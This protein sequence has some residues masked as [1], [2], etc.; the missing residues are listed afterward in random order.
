M[1]ISQVF[2]EL[3]CTPA[4]LT[5]AEARQR[6]E[7]FGPN[8]LPQVKGPGPLR[9]LLAQFD[10]VLVV[11]MG[12]LTIEAG[13]SMPL[14]AFLAGL[15]L[16]ET[17]YRHQVEADIRPFRGLLLGLFFMTVGLSMDLGLVSERLTDVLVV[18]LGLLTLKAALIFVLCLA[19]RLPAEEALRAGFLLAQG[20]EFAFV[21]FDVA[22]A[23]QVLPLADGQ[24]LTAAVAL[25]MILTPFLAELGRLF[26]GRL[27]C[28][29]ASDLVALREETAALTDHVVV[30][31]FG[32]V[33]QTVAK[34]LAG[35]D[36]PYVALDLDARRIA[37]A[38]AKGLPV[39]YGDAGRVDVL[40]AAGA[41][42]ARAAV[43][44]IDQPP[45]VDR[46]VSALHSHFPEL[47]IFVRGRDPEHGTQLIGSG[48]TAVVPEVV[49]ASLQLGVLVLNTLGAGAG[50][51][52]R[53][54]ELRRDNYVALRE[55]TG[56]DVQER[57]A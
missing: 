43:L 16:S 34:V 15:L 21:L 26:A 23:R 14:G 31:G 3:A 46:V 20:G 29:S 36:V 5:E 45:V 22:T 24:M 56:G 32:R 28:P 48:A 42:R 33:G 2:Q 10:S 11:G 37:R 54:H 30:A 1:P 27:R 51:A 17:E 8:R 19:F 9:R 18:V 4:G 38:R 52:A 41:G 44:T 12:W 13:S 7:R 35:A 40:A 53:A 55:I 25:S 6:V 50:G 57:G 47:R 39:F 49:E